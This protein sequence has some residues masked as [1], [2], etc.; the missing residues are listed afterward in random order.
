MTAVLAVGVA[1]DASELVKGDIRAVGFT[2][3]GA[4]SFAAAEALK[5]PAQDL[6]PAGAVSTAAGSTT[7]SSSTPKSSSD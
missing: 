5:S 7:A 6:G 4:G 2:D 3:F 1:T